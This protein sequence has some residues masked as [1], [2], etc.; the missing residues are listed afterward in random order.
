MLGAVTSHWPEY[1]MEGAELG[2]LMVLAC[3]FATLLEYPASPLHEALTNVAV[4]HTLMG[5]AMAAT[6]VA[7]IY[8]PWGRQSGA[9][10][11]PAVTLTFFR[12]G[13]VAPWDAGFYIGAHFA[14]GVTGAV[15]TAAVLGRWVA[16]PA[17]NYAVT[18]PG[19][20]GPGAAFAGEFATSF[21]FMTVVLVAINAPLLERFTG[22]FVGVIVAAFILVETPLSVSQRTERARPGGA[23]RVSPARISGWRH[24]PRW[25][26]T[27]PQ[28]PCGLG[29]SRWASFP[30]C[31]DEHQ[32]GADVRI[33][34]PGPSLDGVVGVLHRTPRGDAAGSGG[35]SAAEWA[36]ECADRQT[37]SR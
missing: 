13:K 1:L 30:R 14:G 18:T 27:S 34:R 25:T 8:S 11:N 21:V 20:S 37:V 6:V 35:V 36:S 10:F 16:D 26:W 15:L 4:R 33:G 5:V 32:P 7:L 31:G 24:G 19:P 23:G 22:L 2:I 29:G 28:G 9:H 3:C 17:V 12:L